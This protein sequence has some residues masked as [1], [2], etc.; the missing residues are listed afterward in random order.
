MMMMMLC[1]GCACACEGRQSVK[2]YYYEADVDLAN[3]DRPTWDSQTYE[4]VDV[5]STDELLTDDD[6]VFINRQ[7]RSLA[8]SSR[9]LY[10]AVRDE[11]SCTTIISLTVYY[12]V[13]PGVTT[14]LTTFSRTAAATQLTDVLPVVGVCVPHAVCSPPHLS[15]TYLCTSTGRWYHYTGTCRCEPGYQP[16][17]QLT[18]CIGWL[19][20][21]YVGFVVQSN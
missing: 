14:A 21:S 1:V 10:V 17:R 2:L 13:C 12:H 5:L 20:L 8:V 18:Q 16:N 19:A 3:S 11:G 15:P 7:T 9:G 4:L 6:D